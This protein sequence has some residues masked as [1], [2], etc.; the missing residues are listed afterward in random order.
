MFA[1]QRISTHLDAS[2]RI[3]AH[4]SASQRISIYLNASRHPG[5]IRNALP[6]GECKGLTGCRYGVTSP[7]SHPIHNPTLPLYRASHAIPSH[8]AP[9]LPTPRHPTLPHAIPPISNPTS[10]FLLLPPLQHLILSPRNL[11]LRPYP[12]PTFPLPFP[13]VQV[14]LESLRSSDEVEFREQ[15]SNQVII[16]T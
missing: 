12:S 16:C 1:S 11:I 7:I 9:S 10:P 8:P 3:S 14:S 2:Q 5:Q 6:R 4:L 15:L 13:L